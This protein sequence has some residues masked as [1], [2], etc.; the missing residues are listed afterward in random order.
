MGEHWHRKVVGALVVAAWTLVAPVAAI[1]DERVT[2]EGLQRELQELRRRDAER[3]REVESLKDEVRRLRATREASASGAVAPT[4]AA[5]APTGEAAPPSAALDAAVGALASPASQTQPAPTSTVPSAL[6]ARRIGNAQ[7]K[8]LDL[9]F[10]T[11]AAVGGSTV[12]DAAIAQLQGGAHDPKRRG[13]TLQ[14]AELSF[15]GAVDPYFNAEAHVVFTPGHVELEEAFFTTTSLPWNLQL[16]GGYFLTEFGRINPTHSHAWEWVDQPVVNTRMFG[17]EGLRAPG[18]RL[19]WLAPVPWF[20]ELHVGVQN[21]NEGEK[22]LSFLADEAVGGRPA[23]KTSTGSVKDLLYLARWNNSWN[24]S[25]SLT[26]VLGVSGL[27]GPN[28]TGADGRSYVYGADM[29]WKWQPPDHFR[30]WPFVRWQT[31]VMRRD[32]VADRF[33]AGTEVEPPADDHGH[34][35]GAL[36]LADEDDEHDDHDEHDDEELGDLPGDRYHD[37]GLYTQLLWGFRPGWAAG[38]RYEY[39]TGSGPSVSDGGRQADFLRDDRHRV[40]PLIIWQPSEFS[41]IRLQYDFDHADF[42]PSGD[43]HSLWLAFEVL[44]GAHP[45]HQY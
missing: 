29:M 8:L 40:S 18:A 3:Q 21:A 39:A 20:A 26:T 22:T 38:L 7:I 16:E 4:T 28:S 44:Y 31:E 15:A 23:V 45:A 14:Q 19:G 6:A 43:A 27:F 42:L 35:H 9:S 37:W 17:P 1:G 36:R 12:R 25:D 13:F 5:K 32:Y 34:D 41:R 11:L 33:V 2:L 10:D 24:W 30:G